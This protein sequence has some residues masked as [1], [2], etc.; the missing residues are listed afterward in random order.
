MGQQ[1]AGR[2]SFARAL[3]LS[4]AAWSYMQRPDFEHPS[5]FTVFLWYRVSQP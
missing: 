2:V 3:S 4:L 1:E 5:V